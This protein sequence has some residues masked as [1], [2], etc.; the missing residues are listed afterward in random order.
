MGKPKKG[1]GVNEW[2]DKSKFS[3]RASPRRAVEKNEWHDKSKFSQIATC[4]KAFPSLFL[5]IL[6]DYLLPDII[7]IH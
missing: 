6:G 7:A 4:Y 5:L 2:H 1:S 3:Q